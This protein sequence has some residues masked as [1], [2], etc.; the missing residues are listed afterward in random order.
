FPSRNIK[1]IHVIYERTV[2]AI[3][4]RENGNIRLR[5]CFGQA[6]NQV[7][8]DWHSRNAPRRTPIRSIADSVTQPLPHLAAKPNTNQP[9]EQSIADVTA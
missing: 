3:R 7:K 2:S 8:K 9:R 5:E 1:C 6:D 4:F